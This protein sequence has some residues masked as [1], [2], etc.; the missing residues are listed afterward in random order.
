M[1]RKWILSVKS[2]WLRDFTLLTVRLGDELESFSVFSSC[3]IVE[4]L[5]SIGMVLK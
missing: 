1:A 3:E 2:V 5:R 4:A